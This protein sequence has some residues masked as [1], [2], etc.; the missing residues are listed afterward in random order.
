MTIIKSQKAKAELQAAI[1]EDQAKAALQTTSPLQTREAI[2]G[3]WAQYPKAKILFGK[4]MVTWRGSSSTRPAVSGFWAAYPYR[5]WVKTSSMPQRTIQ[6]YFDLLEEHGLIERTHG[7]HGGTR[8]LT[9]IRPTALA[10]KLS[11]HRPTDWP[12]LEGQVAKQGKSSNQ[13]AIAPVHLVIEVDE[14]KPATLEEILVIINGDDDEEKPA[15]WE[16]IM[17]INNETDD[18]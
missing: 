14:D 17:A 6:R 11:D 16:E 3:F 4:I 9:F 5:Y 8:Q 15:T 12:H 13:K 10:L 7:K 18:V 2:K 1:A